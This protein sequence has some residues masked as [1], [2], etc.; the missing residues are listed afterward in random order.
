MQGV[1]TAAAS[2]CDRGTIRC[3]TQQPGER[4]SNVNRVFLCHSS[5]DKEPV[6]KLYEQLR[7]AGFNP[8]LDERDILP[9]Q[10]WELEIAKAVRT[11]AV[12]LVCLS[13]SAVTNTGYIHRE[14]G[15]ALDVAAEQPEGTIFVIPV[16]LEECDVPTRLKQ[17]N[18]VNLFEEQGYGLILRA[19]AT[20]CYSSNLGKDR[21]QATISELRMLKRHATA[22][23]GVA[24]SDQC[25]VSASGDETLKVWDI[26][27]GR[28]VH[29]LRGHS[30]SVRCVAVSPDSLH[31]VSGSQD[32]TLKL[33]DLKAGQELR[34]FEN[35]SNLVSGVALTPDGSRAVSASWDETL[36]VWDL[37][38]GRERCTLEGHSNRVSAVALCHDGSCAVSASWDKTLK[39]W[40]LESGRELRALLGHSQAVKAVAVN[41]HIAVSASADKTLK[42]WDLESGGELRTLEGHL[43]AVTGVAISPDGHLVLSASADDTLRVWELATGAVLATFSIASEVL[44]CAWASGQDMIGGDASGTIHFLRCEV[45]HAT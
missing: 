10:D 15:Y 27:S 25:V 8:W 45:H 18:W 38:S 31:V 20:K 6:R 5:R 12:V 44:C 22:V 42:L 4:P 43:Q 32:Q 35:H 16:R 14:I 11:S 3:M 28:K 39:V 23:W 30:D 13:K 40:D 41:G 26:N 17:W 1:D 21:A 37:E 29:T 34:T 19:L 2:A 7:T 33:W 24:S 36:K 9:G